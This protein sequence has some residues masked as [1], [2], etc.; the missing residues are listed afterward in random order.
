MRRHGPWLIVVAAAAALVARSS[1]YGLLGF[2]CYPMIVSSR[3]RSLADFAGNFTEKLMDGRYVSD[4]YRPFMNLS[5]ATDEAVWGLNPFGYQL[6]NVVVFAACAWTVHVLT[7][8]LAGRETWVAPLAALAVFLLHPLHAEVLPVPPRRAETLCC[9]FMAAALAWQLSSR[10]LASRRPAFGPAV[11]TLLAI[12]SKETGYVLPLLIFVAVY[13]HSTRDG[14]APRLRHAAIA[15]IPHFAVAGVMLLARWLVLGGMG[16][17]LSVPLAEFPAS[18]LGTAWV[19]GEGLLLPQTPMR[20]FAGLAL[21][22][23]AVAFVLATIVLCG[24]SGNR[25]ETR[26]RA[27]RTASFAAVWLLLIVLTYAA[28]GLVGAWYYPV[29][30][31]G[32]AILVGVLF[33]RFVRLARGDGLV[34]VGAMTSLAL[35]GGLLFWQAVYSPI[36]HHYDEWRRASDAGSLFLD[37]ARERVAAADA[38]TVVNAP[39]LPFWVAS[40][41]GGPTIRGAAVLTDYSVQAW[42]DLTLPGRNVRVG[43][44][45]A[46]PAPPGPD[47]V[48]LLIT[49]RREGY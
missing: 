48:L 26:Q 24:R 47:E 30:L 49:R 45:R 36:F 19:L 9:L 39:P 3:V 25:D 32:W 14:R 43:F 21:V 5:I 33:E 40:E 8:R 10:A 37:Q 35:A 11:A 22:V 20:N 4:F 17:H 31:A 2:D 38:G 16:G 27:N 12:A 7:R 15:T 28:T 18:A 34:R 42:A 29:P 6:T 44:A 1:R 41:P 13:L 46:N 23:M